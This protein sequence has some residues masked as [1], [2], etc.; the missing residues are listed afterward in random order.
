M[1]FLYLKCP[2]IIEY[3]IVLF[4]DMNAAKIY[5]KL[6]MDGYGSLI[7]Y[8]RA[9]RKDT[10]DFIRLRDNEM[11][12]KKVT[13]CT[14]IAFNGLN[15][16]NTNEKILVVGSIQ[17][18]KTTACQIIQQIGRIRN[19]KVIAKYF[20]NDRI[21][22]E[23]IDDKIMREQEHLDVLLK[24]CSV[25]NV[26]NKWLDEKSVEPTNVSTPSQ[27]R[28]KPHDTLTPR[29]DP[30]WQRARPLRATPAS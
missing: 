12:E 8:I 24:G 16:K 30:Y 2:T 29:C 22:S 26:E 10:E 13:I 5:E 28:A 27:V 3:S 7:S 14:C 18:G 20:F 21:Y 17:Q 19:S 15:F 9:D 23:D 6:V 1:I 11:L 25:I 4:D